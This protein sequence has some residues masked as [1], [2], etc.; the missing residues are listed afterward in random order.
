MHLHILFTRLA[1]C[2]L[3]IGLL[4]CVF[5]VPIL[6]FLG[7]HVSA[8][9][10]V[11]LVSSSARA[12]IEFELSE[13]QKQLRRFLG[14]INYYHRFLPHCATLLAPLNDMTVSAKTSN[15]MIESGNLY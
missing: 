8:G 1:E 13:Q 15:K 12:I 9:G 14:M 7:H 4:K 5:G 2:S 10:I 11:L 3:I 6:D